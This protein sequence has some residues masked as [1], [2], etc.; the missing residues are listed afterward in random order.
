MNGTD[1]P[2]ILY[3]MGRGH[4]GSTTLDL[5]LGNHPEVVTAGEITN[6]FRVPDCPCTCGARLDE[7][8]FWGPV[9]RELGERHPDTS[10]EEF[11]RMLGRIDMPQRIPAILTGVGLP[12]WVKD[13]YL[14]MNRDLYA[15]IARRAGARFVVDSSKDLARA[16]LLLKRFRK[17]KVIHMVRDGRGE[18]W[19]RL[20]RLR[21]GKPFQVLRRDT[22]P[23]HHAPAMALTAWAWAASNS[24]S[25]LYGWMNPGRVH[26]LFYE[27][28]CENPRREIERLGR[29]LDLDLSE[30]A[31]RIERGEPFSFGHNV[32]GSILLAA[33]SKT[34]TFR[35]DRAWKENLPGR[36]RALYAILAW[37]LI[38]CFGYHRKA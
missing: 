10:W 23:K 34:L 28:L 2:T 30:M 37:P 17:A 24:L 19:S 31:G 14:P 20:K 36:Y 8:P 12:A 15:T 22:H 33:E 11:G 5:V 29:F 21:A 7:C 13:R 25:I 3:I 1:D 6:G 4:S 27:D 26:R 35:P 38:L 16:A 32:S 9:R 18:L